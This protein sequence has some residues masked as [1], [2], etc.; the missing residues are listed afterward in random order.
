MWVEDETRRNLSGMVSAMD[1]AV[2]NLTTAL[3]ETGMWHDTLFIFSTDNGGPLKEGASNYPLRGGKA[4]LW[5]GGVRGLGFVN[6]GAKAG[7]SRDVRGTVN[8]NLMHVTDWL[9]TLCEVAGC[10]LSGTKPLDGLSAWGHISTAEATSLRTEICHEIVDVKGQQKA[11]I[12]LGDYKL[13]MGEAGENTSMQLFNV[14]ED[15]GETVDLTSKMPDKV[16]ELK[17]RLRHFELSRV[18]D[19]AMEKAP[20]VA[21]ANPSL[22]GGVWLPWMGEDGDDGQAVPIS[23]SV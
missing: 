12:R 5:E 19:V 16:E 9:P 8:R 6:G 15:V 4:N 1:E 22:H 10:N 14:V 21:A 23:F 13:I 20:P 18:G 3:K 2:G 7:L 17:N 11:A